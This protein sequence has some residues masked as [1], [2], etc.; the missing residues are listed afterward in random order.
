M[1][2]IRPKYHIKNRLSE[3]QSISILVVPVEHYTIAP[4]M[5]ETINNTTGRLRVVL[6]SLQV[7]III[8][9]IYLEINTVGIEP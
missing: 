2:F 8:S 7:K 6:K 3:H 9:E 5:T 4:S 1:I